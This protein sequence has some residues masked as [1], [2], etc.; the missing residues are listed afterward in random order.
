MSNRN[1]HPATTTVAVIGAGPVGLAAAAHLIERGLTPIVLEAGEGPADAIRQWGH[2]RLF[3]PWR[4]D[5]DA[6]ARRLLESH[7]WIAPEP[8]AIPTGGNRVDRHLGS[9][10]HRLRRPS[11][12]PAR[13]HASPGSAAVC[14]SV[15]DAD[16]SVAAT[17]GLA[18]SR[19]ASKTAAMAAMRWPSAGGAT[20]VRES[21]RRSSH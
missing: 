11:R 12:R 20:R 8:D 10:G 19:S 18:R 6:A 21:R 17:A 7:G 13:S 4:F 9:H 15:A 16:K 3:S 5:I 2:V 1:E 14:A